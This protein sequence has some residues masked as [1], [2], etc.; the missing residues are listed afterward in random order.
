[1]GKREFISSDSFF[2]SF[3]EN[4]QIIQ[5]RNLEAGTDTEAWRKPAYWLD[6]HGLLNP[7]FL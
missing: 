7:T 2:P 6:L 4:S 3:R 1:V 5:V